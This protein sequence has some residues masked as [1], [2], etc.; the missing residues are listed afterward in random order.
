M[1]KT[2]LFEGMGKPMLEAFIL[3]GAGAAFMG[4][5]LGLGVTCI[6]LLK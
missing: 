1:T 4:V 2:K 3:M 5:M 6:H